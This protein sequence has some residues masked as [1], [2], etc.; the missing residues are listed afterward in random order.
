MEKR[1]AERTEE[2]READ[3]GEERSREENGR[4]EKREAE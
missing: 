1:G 4:V 3:G 2:I